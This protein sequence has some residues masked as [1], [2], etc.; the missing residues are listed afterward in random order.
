MIFN[1]VLLKY[2]GTEETVEVPEGVEKIAAYAFKENKSLKAITLPDTVTEIGDNAFSHSGLTHMEIKNSV[3]S[4]GS[5]VFSCCKELETVSLP[6][7]ITTIPEA[8]FFHCEKLK[9][10]II[11]AEVTVI[12]KVAFCGCTAMKRISLPEKLT[13]V[14]RDAFSKCSQLTDVSF[15]GDDAQW[16]RIAI[17]SGN[18]AL[19]KAR[20][21][22]A[23]SPKSSPI[24]NEAAFP[25]KEPISSPNKEK[26]REPKAETSIFEKIKRLFRQRS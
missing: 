14:S 8:L 19:T 10:I 13:T 4:I 20:M 25:S 21:K 9:E 1:C 12:D 2:Q 18:E 26:T 15:P 5:E 17:D 6:E 23:D 11:P 16:N 22:D 7:A 24:E 3:V